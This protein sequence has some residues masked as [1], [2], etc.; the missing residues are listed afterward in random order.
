MAELDRS[1]K[2]RMNTSG[3]DLTRM[4]AVVS[5]IREA[6]NRATRNSQRILTDIS[7]LIHSALLTQFTQEES[8][9]LAALS[10]GIKD[11]GVPLAALSICGRGTEEIRFTKLLGYFLDPSKP[12]G[13]KSHFLR[14]VLEPELHDQSKQI[15]EQ[16]WKSARVHLECLLDKSAP[17][18]DNGSFLD[19]LVKLSGFNVFIEQKIKSNESR[20][21]GTT[22]LKRYSDAIRNNTSLFHPDN[23]Y[24]YLTPYGRQPSD[25]SWLPLSHR[26]I[27]SRSTSLL[28]DKSLSRIAKN[29]LCCLLWDLLL[30]PIATE[31]QF[32]DDFLWHLARATSRPERYL[33]LKR[34]WASTIGFETWPTLIAIAEVLNES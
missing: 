6:H 22:Q 26:E 12:H 25:L 31:E 1:G 29:N 24:L 27:F 33:D 13:L 32:L 3:T 7:D 34:W 5:S 10:H 18:V 11:N 19:I 17:V 16:D 23:V 4:Q 30:G 28:K 9:C 14:A 15:S 21:N 2:T 20:Y 8:P